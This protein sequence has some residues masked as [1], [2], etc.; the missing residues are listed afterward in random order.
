MKVNI[1]VHLVTSKRYRGVQEYIVK[2]SRALMARNNNEYSLS[3]FDYNK[4]R[5]HEELVKRFF[6]DIQPDLHVCDKMK[7]S[8]SNF[9]NAYFQQSYDEIMGVSADV[10][11]FPHL[12][13]IPDN[14]NAAMVVTCHD[15]L[16]LRR[17][18]DRIDLNFTI[19]L[20]R[21]NKISPIIIAIT[22]IVKE[23]LCT[24]GVV[25]EE[26]IFVVHNGVD[27]KAFHPSLN[28]EVR[29][30]YNIFRPYFLVLGGIGQ[31][32]KNT[33][34]IVE[35]FSILPHN[36]DS[37]LVLIGDVL[38]KPIENESFL[39]KNNNIIFTGFVTEEE[40]NALLTESE[41]LIYPSLAEGFGLPIIEAQAAGT[42]VITSNIS[43]M[44]EVA[45]DA[46]ILIDPYNTEQLAF[47]ME[48]VLTDT[49]LKRELIAKGKR[50][51]NRFSW[52]KCARETEEVY[53]IAYERYK[54][55]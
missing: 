30:K 42:P 29:K 38:N 54:S 8:E 22:K 55:K 12:P 28:S 5:G 6:D 14:L 25:P 52:N 53:K 48:R 34:R 41:C 27:T 18:L 32:S 45:G 15:T 19:G 4:E 2:L 39:S 1:D 31:V 33:N 11:H 24:L 51:V 26:N 50:N 46:A 9:Y 3:C 49:F 7:L 10:F 40:K 35:A 17:E 44:P 13:H 36:K 16:P 43:S 21:S 23:E 47:E 37:N 20:Y